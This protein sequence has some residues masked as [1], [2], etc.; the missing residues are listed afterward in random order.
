M[1]SVPISCSLG[2]GDM[3]ARAASW[4][5]L[6]AQALGPAS[7]SASASRG[8]GSWTVEFAR[9]GLDLAGLSQ[10][11]EAEVECCPFFIFTVTVKVDRVSL[12]VTAPP[13]AAD[14]AALLLGG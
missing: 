8:G 10:L 5:A 6:V 14:L 4:K 1:A 11:V 9:K 7:P 3:A 2:A 12:S 13:E